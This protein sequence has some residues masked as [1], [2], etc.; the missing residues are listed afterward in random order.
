[1]RAVWLE[2]PE[3]LLNFEARYWY[4][5][6]DFFKN[7]L[8]MVQAYSE[9]KR[10]YYAGPIQFFFLFASL[11]F[12]L[13]LL[14]SPDSAVASLEMEVVDSPSEHM[15][16]IR[17][18][19]EKMGYLA[20]S[21][22]NYFELGMP[23]FVGLIVAIFYRKTLNL[24]ES[25]AYS[26]YAVAFMLEIAPLVLIPFGRTEVIKT[27]E[28]IMYIVLIVYFFSFLGKVKILHGILG[29]FYV[30]IALILYVSSFILVLVL[31]YPLWA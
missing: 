23:L 10:K 22:T 15:T 27:I 16:R 30:A 1:M 8:K 3:A 14:L 9:G 29:L 2:M 17:S 21:F 11:S 19:I 25:F 5:M 7:P 26:F 24:A 4:S 12:F 31:T 20:S 6:R 13:N 28:T 18:S